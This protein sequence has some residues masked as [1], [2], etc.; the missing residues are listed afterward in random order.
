[1]DENW[2]P[3]SLTEVLRRYLL[4]EELHHGPGEGQ[5]IRREAETPLDSNRRP[6]QSLE[7]EKRDPSH[8]RDS[9]GEG[10]EDGI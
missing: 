3:K 2:K 9:T 6:R 10:I 8:Q 5:Q 4:S 1:M 7:V